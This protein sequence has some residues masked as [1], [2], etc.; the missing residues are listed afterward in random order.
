MN[1]PSASRF[2][3]LFVALLSLAPVTYAGGWDIVTLKDF[4]DFAVAGQA[5]NLSFTVWAPSLEPLANLQPR[6]RATICSGPCSATENRR[7][8]A[9]AS[10]KAGAATGAYTAKLILPEPGDWMVT[11]NTEY[12]GASTLPPLKVVA[13]GTPSPTPISAAA[14]GMRLF[15][16]KGCN[17]CHLRDEAGRVYG[18]DLTGKRFAS[19]YLKRFLADPSITSVPEEVCNRDRSYCGAPYAMPNPNLKD[20]EI[21]ALIAFIN[22]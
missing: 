8:T 14:R 18:P 3:L 7:L 22:D 9:K 12:A 19:E 10:V 17:S 16:A 1:N 20:A 4:P 13:P 21:E 5:L 15:T 11:I 2:T 6:V